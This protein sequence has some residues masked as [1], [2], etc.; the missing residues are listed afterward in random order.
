[1]TGFISGYGNICK[2]KLTALFAAALCIAITVCPFAAETDLYTVDVESGYLAL[3]NAKSYDASNEIGKLYDGETVTLIDDSDNTYWTVNSPKL[4]MTGYVNADYLEEGVQQPDGSGYTVSV[5]EGYLALRSDKSGDES[6][7]IGR[8]YTG[9]TVYV[10]DDTDAQYWYVQ[11]VEL[12]RQGFVNKEYLISS[13]HAQTS[14]M[15]V[16][17]S[18]GYLALRSA[19]SEDPACEIGQLHS[20]ETVEVYSSGDDPFAYVYV[21]ALG[22]YGYVNKAFLSS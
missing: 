20:G 5:S 22:L 19:P 9:D 7:E 17:V 2:K 3:R 10:L 4:D 8:L 16:E 18:E 6:S 12:G 21:P 11:A 13:Q 15:T 14:V 1:M